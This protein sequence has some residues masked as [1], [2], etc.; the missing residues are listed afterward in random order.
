MVTPRRLGSEGGAV[1]VADGG[2]RKWGRGSAEDGAWGHPTGQREAG[3]GGAAVRQGRKL[4]EFGVMGAEDH[5]E[6][7]KVAGLAACCVGGREAGGKRSFPG[8]VDGSGSELWVQCVQF[9][10]EFCCEGER[11]GSRWGV[12]KAAAPPPPV[13]Q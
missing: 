10:P 7:G 5:S 3:E 13:G 1:G 4:G 2:T 9:F 8:T 11:G 12:A 6:E